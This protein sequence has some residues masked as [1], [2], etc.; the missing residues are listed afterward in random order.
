MTKELYATGK[1]PQLAGENAIVSVH[2]NIPGT[3]EIRTMM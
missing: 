2:L 3:K 1:D